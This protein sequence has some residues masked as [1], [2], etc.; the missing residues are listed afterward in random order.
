MKKV[1]PPKIGHFR[2]GLLSS[3]L[4]KKPSKWLYY[5]NFFTL[6]TRKM[7]FEPLRGFFGQ[8]WR[9]QTPPKMANFGGVY[10]LHFFSKTT[11]STSKWHKSHNCKIRSNFG[12]PCRTQKSIFFHF[13]NRYQEIIPKTSIWS[14]PHH[15]SSILSLFLLTFLNFVTFYLLTL[16]GRAGLKFHR[17]SIPT[18]VLKVLYLYL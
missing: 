4:A 1:D 3:L 9:K 18:K 8:K 6:V 13:F 2:G 15:S 16:N 7:H 12:V 11:L 5:E 14:L 17:N 10:F